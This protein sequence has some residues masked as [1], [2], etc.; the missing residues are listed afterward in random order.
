MP[1]PRL[2]NNNRSEYPV[3][4]LAGLS[5]LNKISIKLAVTLLSEFI[6]TLVCAGADSIAAPRA[7][8]T[9]LKMGVATR[10]TT[11][12]TV[13]FAPLSQLGNGLAVMLPP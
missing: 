8:R 5:L 9:R 6:V 4:P 7:K 12:P 3:A 10:V 1:T 2:P 13:Y 11:V